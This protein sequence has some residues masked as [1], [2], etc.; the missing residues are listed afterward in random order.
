[1]PTRA[2]KNSLVGRLGDVV[3]DIGEPLNGTGIVGDILSIPEF[4]LRR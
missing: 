4:F 3:A 2:G 1:M